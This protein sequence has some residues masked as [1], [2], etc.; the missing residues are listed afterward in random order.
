MM[1]EDEDDSHKLV[2]GTA[3]AKGMYCKET[4]NQVFYPP[5]YLSPKWVLPANGPV[6]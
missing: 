3:I 1:I 4:T 5:Q 2:E 6:F